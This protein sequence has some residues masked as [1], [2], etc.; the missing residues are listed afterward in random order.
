MNFILRKMFKKYVS[1]LN[2]VYIFGDTDL[3][4]S[5]RY[6]IGESLTDTQI[7]PY[8]I[9]SFHSGN[10]LGMRGEPISN[11][12]ALAHFEKAFQIIKDKIEEE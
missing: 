9:I 11:E 3:V 2:E 5:C 1:P 4:P 10:L 12:E 7:R 8:A 6:S